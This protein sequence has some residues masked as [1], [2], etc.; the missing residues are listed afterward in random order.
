M[1][2]FYYRKVTKEKP[3]SKTSK[4]DHPLGIG[5]GAP[6]T[7]IGWGHCCLSLSLAHS[8]ESSDYLNTMTNIFTVRN[9]EY[10][11]GQEEIAKLDYNSHYEAN[12]SNCL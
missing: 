4:L 12:H 3:P 6:I 2:I 11:K 1:F 10:F 8:N 9:N 7:A 5:T